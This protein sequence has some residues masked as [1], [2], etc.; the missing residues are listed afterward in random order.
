MSTTLQFLIVIL[1]LVGLFMFLPNILAF[2]FGS[3]GFGDGGGTLSQISTLQSGMLAISYDGGATFKSAGV[4]SPGAPSILTVNASHGTE[5]AA[6]SDK[7][8]YAGTDQGLLISKDNGLSWHSF[9][10]LEKNIDAKT[11]VNDLAFNPLTGDIYAAAY[12]NDHGVVYATADNFFTVLPI[13]TEAKM[14]VLS[15]ASDRNFLYLG[16][17]DGRMLRYDYV[18]KNFQEVKNFDSGIKNL[19]LTE[20]GKNIFVA[21][22]NGNM[23]SSEDFGVN[24]SVINTSSQFAF[25]SSGS[26]VNLTPDFSNTAILYLASTSGIF[27]SVDKGN[28]WAALNTILPKNPNIASLAV[29]NGRI[30]V[31]T[32]SK[33]YV[34]GDG[35]ASWNIEEP[36]PTTNKLGALYVAND[37]QLVI[38]GVK[39]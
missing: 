2:S 15:L 12:K 29:Q 28:S 22:V 24:W 23:Y 10:D 31:T 17:M 27:R 18:A 16:L 26:S 11:T 39:K 8:Y 32:G 5:G 19:N 37:G 38:V 1:V 7:T 9:V 21:L 33:L 25:F 36:M 20:G 13:W 3:F 30:Y 14:K 34:S 4:D 35:G 6:F